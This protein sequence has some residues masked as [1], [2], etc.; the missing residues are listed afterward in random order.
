MRRVT[1]HM[2]MTLSDLIRQRMQQKGCSIRDLAAAAGV[3]YEHVRKIVK[4]DALPSRHSLQ[5]LAKVLELELEEVEPLRVADGIRLKYGQ[6]PKEITGRD[7]ELQPIERY[8]HRLTKEQKA[9]VTQLVRTLAH[10]IKRPS[11]EK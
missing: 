10:Q 6:I 4:G 2:S 8:W 9:T 7:P 5:T 3:T 1:K 11:E